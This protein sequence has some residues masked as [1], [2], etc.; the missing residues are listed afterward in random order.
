MS[1][2]EHARQVYQRQQ[3]EQGG[4]GVSVEER[5]FANECMLPVVACTALP[6]RAN[7]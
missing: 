3:G 5:P 2:R 1:S 7:L 4:V 6:S